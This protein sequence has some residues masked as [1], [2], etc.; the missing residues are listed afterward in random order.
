MK[1]R[2][3]GRRIHIAGS[4]PV[5]VAHAA[6]EDVEAARAFVSALV[7]DLM[8]RG[9]S[10]VVPVDAEKARPVDGLP[11]CFDWLI[12]N[13]INNSIA[14]RPADAINPLAIAVLHNKSEDQVPAEFD[15]LWEALRGSD[16]VQ[17]ESAASW[18]MA[19]KRM[20]IQARWGDILITLGG[21][22]GVL[23]LANLY[24]DAGK[25]VIPLNL[26]VCSEYEGSRKLFNFGLSSQNA[27]KLFQADGVGAHGWL[28]RI[29][30]RKTKP[31]ADR[32]SSFV[33]LLESLA[34]PKAFAVRLL[35]PEHADF[36]A[37]EEQ[38]TQVVQPVLEGELGY[39]LVVVDGVQPLEHPRLDQEIFAKLHRSS[40]VVADITGLRPNCFVEMGYAL[41]RQLPTMMM[42]KEGGEHPFDLYT[43]SGL[44]WNPSHSPDARRQKFREH[45]KAIRTRPPLVPDE[46]L[47]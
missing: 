15:A 10:F 42:G 45:W 29:N 6:S 43:L 18:N 22:E 28:N 14:N 16:L 7:Q 40:F 24:H 8:R 23:Y 44:H 2:L 1:S 21:S 5:D 3:H 37:V 35:N 33:G 27:P 47:I 36:A 25:P 30:F 19:S 11:I 38:F 31:V 46:P 4:I 12:W 39:Q 13:A 17:L 41:G 9:A 26:P 20:E 34:P 32:V